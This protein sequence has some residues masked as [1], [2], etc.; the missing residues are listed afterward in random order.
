MIAIVTSYIR[1]FILYSWWYDIELVKIFFSL[2]FSPG[3]DSR[4]QKLFPMPTRWTLSHKLVPIRRVFK[5]VG[6]V[7]EALS[8]GSFI[9]HIFD[10]VG[11]IGSFDVAASCSTRFVD[12]GLSG[13]FYFPR[14]FTLSTTFAIPLSLFSHSSESLGYLFL[15]LVQPLFSP[16]QHGVGDT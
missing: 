12:R 8:C 5:G 15:N 10:R 9:V 4:R 16:L 2:F 11:R 1:T 3:P 14:S 7:S 6:I 13:F